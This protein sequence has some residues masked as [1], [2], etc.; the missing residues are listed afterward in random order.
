M[1]DLE[2]GMWRPRANFEPLL[3]TKKQGPDAAPDLSQTSPFAP[4]FKREVK[5]AFSRKTLATLEAEHLPPT[6]IDHRRAPS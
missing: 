2:G 4:L 1:G 6:L 5:V 3:L